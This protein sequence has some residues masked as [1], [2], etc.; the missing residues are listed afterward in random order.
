MQFYDAPPADTQRQPIEPH[1]IIS[2]ILP[3][4][5]QIRIGGDSNVLIDGLHRRITI[6]QTDGSSVGIGIIGDTGELGTFVTDANGNLIS[7]TVNGTTYYYD[8]TTNKNIIQIG[9]LPDGSYGMAVAKAGYN[10]SDGIS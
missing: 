9:K 7:K 5:T 3:G 4:A 8:L 1:T 10:V 2:G 6:T